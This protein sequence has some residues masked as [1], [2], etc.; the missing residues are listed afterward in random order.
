MPRS[1]GPS[2][3]STTWSVPD[4]QGTATAMARAS[5]SSEGTATSA[6]DAAAR[7]TRRGWRVIPVPFRSKNPGFDRWQEM[8]LSE[9]DLPFHFNGKP[10]NVGILT[11]EPSGWLIDVDLDH[12][13]AIEL[14]PQFLPH[15][16]CVFGRNSKRRSHWLYRVATPLATKKFKSK[17]AGMILE[18]RSTGCQT[19]VPPSVHESGE[20]IEWDD[21]GAEPAVVDPIELMNGARRTAD[22]VKIGLGE[23]ATTKKSKPKRSATAVSPDDVLA[24][25]RSSRCLAAM[26]GMDMADNKDGSA[27]LFAA[28][29]RGRTRSGRPT[30]D[31]RHSPIRQAASVSEGM[32]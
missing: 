22:A 10:Q 28:A 24:D 30:G 29:S 20:P 5:H 16:P 26:S 2:A 8:R 19:V 18:V 12:P 7:Y 17:S 14:A 23:K 3:S 21:E 9:D 15:T 6:A 11:G 31:S 27:R 25:A 1:S 32:D 4:S 13:R